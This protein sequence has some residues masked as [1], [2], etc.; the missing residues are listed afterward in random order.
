MARFKS[1]LPKLWLALTGVSYGKNLSLCGWPVIF[2]FSQACLSFGDDCTINSN[3]LSNL[4]GLYQRTIIVARDQGEIRIGNHVG[5][6]GSTIYARKRIELGDH[7]VVGAN[8]KIMDNDFHPL[9]PDDRRADRYDKLV[10]KP[11]E[12][13]RDVFVGCNCIILKGT[14]L[15]DRCVVGA[16]SVV[17]GTFPADSIVAGN[18]AR[19][20]GK[21]GVEKKDG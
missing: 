20:I 10:C 5:I 1:R 2:R 4:L 3:F 15:G 13:G 17:S 12:I 8:C 16:G 19:V 11:V 6:S 14:K 7:G 18:P 21:V 9:D